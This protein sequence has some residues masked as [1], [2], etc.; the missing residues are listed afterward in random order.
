ML[1]S[2]RD[3]S[4]ALGDALAFAPSG[5]IGALVLA[6]AAVAA[7]VVHEILV[8]L[9]RRLFGD[10]ESYLRSL[11]RAISGLTR[12]AFLIIAL[13]IVLPIAPIDPVAIAILARM[14]TLATIALLGWIAITATHVTGDLYLRRFSLDATDD[15]LA[16]KH[17]TQV[18]ILRRVVDTLI[19]VLTVSAGLM[20]FE[21]VRQYGVSLFASAGVAGL[22]VG[23]AARPMLSNLIAGIQIAT[24]QPIRLG[25]EVVIETQWGRIEEITSTYVVIKLWDLR[26]LIVPLSYFMEKAFENWTRESTNLIGAVSIHVSYLTPIERVRQKAVEIVRASPLW[27]GDVV[28]LVVNEAKETALE[29]RV[30]ASA[31]TSGATADLRSEIR[32]KMIAFLQQEYPTC[33]PPLAPA[34]PQPQSPQPAKPPDVSSLPPAKSN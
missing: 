13:D 9:L 10:Q 17:V 30:L 11:L 23:L 20:T 1:A 6:L 16:R 22:V 34:A 21:S 28:K 4:T 15:L 12:L 14:L 3:A 5:L 24:T 19:I 33:L 2:V 18:R 8:R 7:I 26:R 27:D 29:L 25:D 32:E 31:R